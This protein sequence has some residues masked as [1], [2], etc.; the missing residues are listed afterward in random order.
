M[1]LLDPSIIY[2]NFWS[3]FIILCIYIVNLLKRSLKCF[4]RNP[5]SVITRVFVSHTSAKVLRTTIVA[6][7]ISLLRINKRLVT[8]AWAKYFFGIERSG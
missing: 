8:L 5:E 4:P 6:S 3:M 1:C 7:V 2:M